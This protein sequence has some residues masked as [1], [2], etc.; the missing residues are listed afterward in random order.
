MKA[1]NNNT[2]SVLAINFA[3]G[4]R[5]STLRVYRLIVFGGDRRSIKKVYANEFIRYLP[6]VISRR[7]G[8]LA[9]IALISFFFFLV[10]TPVAS[11]ATGFE[12]EGMILDSTGAAVAGAEAILRPIAAGNGAPAAI[13]RG[14]LSSIP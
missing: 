3:G 9:H 12:I 13:P 10:L 1:S 2:R 5:E 7:L 8:F 11:P 6:L 4:V 14:V